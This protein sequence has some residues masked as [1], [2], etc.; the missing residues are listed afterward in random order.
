MNNN[1]IPL[2]TIQP[3]LNNTTNIN[4]NL[5][6]NNNA[7]NLKNSNQSSKAPPVLSHRGQQSS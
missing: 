7:N 5:L 2:D 1:R 6:P 4:N 3:F